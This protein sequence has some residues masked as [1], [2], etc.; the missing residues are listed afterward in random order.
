MFSSRLGT[1]TSGSTQADIFAAAKEGTINNQIFKERM[2]HD[3]SFVPTLEGLKNVMEK[4]NYA[5]MNYYQMVLA[6][7]EYDCKVGK[8]FLKKAKI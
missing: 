4:E 3:D 5:Y 7:K 6:A 1:F 2:Q 8:Q